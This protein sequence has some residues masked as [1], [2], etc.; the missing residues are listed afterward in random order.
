MKVR[1]NTH[2]VKRIKLRNLMSRHYGR[3]SS[4]AAS[5]M[6]LSG[7]ISLTNPQK[8]GNPKKKQ[9]QDSGLRI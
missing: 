6:T 4:V 5:H 3:L 7:K 1:K 9:I 2:L 8:N